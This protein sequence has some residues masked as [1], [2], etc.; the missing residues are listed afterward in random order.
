MR[1]L[2]RIYPYFSSDRGY[3]RQSNLEHQ[4]GVAPRPDISA[5]EYHAIIKKL[6]MILRGKT[7]TLIDRLERQIKKASARH[8]YEKA[9]VLRDEYLSLKALSQKV[10]LGLKNRVISQSIKL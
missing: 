10:I 1:Y 9:A 8:D 5:S 6:S 3:S 4:I 2:R 7:Q